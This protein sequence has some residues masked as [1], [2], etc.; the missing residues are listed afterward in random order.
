MNQML[1]PALVRARALTGFGELVASLGGDPIAL[2]RRSGLACKI[3]PDVDATLAM[4]GFV[5]LLERAAHELRVPDFGMQL[6]A[7]QGV[8]VI[9]PV[10]LVAMG[11]TTVRDA[12]LLASK[13]LPYHVART[14][15]RLEDEFAP[16]QS[17][18]LYQLP[19]DSECA[20][21]QTTELCCMM[22][23]QGLKILSKN[24]GA[25]WSISLQ[26]QR[27]A[28]ARRYLEH[29]G[30]P[31][32]HAQAFNAIEFPS[33]LLDKT[34]LSA[35]AEISELASRYIDY[36][37]HRHPQDWSRQVEELIARQ[38]HAST[39]TI[40]DIARQ[41]AVNERTLQRRLETQ[42]RQ[43]NQL[44]DQIRVNRAQ[45]YLRFSSLPMT[46]IAPLL[47]YSELRSFTRACQRWFGCPPLKMRKQLLV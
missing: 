16:G 5:G 18:L 19:L 38:L 39:C 21:A 46:E 8:S 42:N 1:S 10:A 45:E 11:A 37:V 20:H 47:G 24:N 25:G 34:L 44:L 15:I 26:H 22:A 4:Q 31:V 13:N 3:D 6:G 2:L 40:E 7:L 36:V 9:G 33:I 32:R 41:L 43:F 35:Q 14:S 30:C 29:F 28:P 27:V 17:R 23:L 12:V